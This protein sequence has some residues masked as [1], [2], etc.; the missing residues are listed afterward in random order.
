VDTGPPSI[1]AQEGNTMIPMN[2][3]AIIIV[4]TFFM[5]MIIKFR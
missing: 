3:I 4:L 5:R 1:V 2:S